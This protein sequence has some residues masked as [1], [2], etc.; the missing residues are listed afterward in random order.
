MVTT[1]FIV[2]AILVVGVAVVLGL[3]ATKP[4]T[5]RIER[6]AR[7]DAPPERVFAFINDFRRWDGWSP[8]EKKDPAIKRSF[9]GAAEGKGAFYEFDGNKQVG[10]GRIAITEAAA[11]RKVVLTLGMTRP[12]ACHNF[13]EFTLQPQGDATEIT[14]AMEGS[15]PF[16]AK[17]MHVFVNMDRMVGKEFES[18]LANLK[19]LSE[20]TTADTAMSPA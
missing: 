16:F 7:I 15:A 11:P 6:K 8:F 3:A 13:I 20:S 17:I 18:G 4:D 1:V 14:W 19:R 9:S 10:A 12:F 2:L 5:C